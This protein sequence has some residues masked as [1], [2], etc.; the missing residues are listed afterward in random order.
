MNTILNA[1]CLQDCQGSISK[2]RD[3]VDLMCP[4]TLR[5]FCIDRVDGSEVLLKLIFGLKNHPYN[6][7]M[8]LIHIPCTCIYTNLSAPQLQNIRALQCV[9]LQCCYCVQGP[10]R[11]AQD[12]QQQ[13]RQQQALQGSTSAG[14][15]PYLATHLMAQ[16][17]TVSMRHAAAAIQVNGVAE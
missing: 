9:W 13:V 8:Y 14:Q 11:T 16:V 3:R 1:T 2:L 7:S 12:F 4:Q 17:S 5:V 6:S 15:T 10:R